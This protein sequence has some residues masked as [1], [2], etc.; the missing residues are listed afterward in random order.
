MPAAAI[1][2]GQF[3]QLDRPIGAEQTAGGYSVVLKLGTAD[4]Y[5]VWTTDGSGNYLSNSAVVAGSDCRVTSLESSFQQDLNGDG[6]IMP[7]S[8]GH[9]SPVRARRMLRSDGG[10]LLRPTRGRTGLSTIV[11]CRRPHSC[12]RQL[13]SF[14]SADPAP[15]GLRAVAASCRKNSDVSTQ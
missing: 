13:G 6:T 10:Q 8:R 11:H 4:Q 7:G 2:Q 14:R 15:S 3:G 12:R 9:R 1:V 5:T